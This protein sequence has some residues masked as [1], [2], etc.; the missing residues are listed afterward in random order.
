M[1]KVLLAVAIGAAAVVIAGCSSPAKQRAEVASRAQKDMVGMS[2]KELFGCAGT[3][4]RSERIDDTEFLTYFGGG[5]SV[6]A[7]VV[8]SNGYGTVAASKN[9]RRYCE[10]TFAIKDGLIQSVNY[11]GRTGGSSSKGEQCAF[12]VENCV[13]Q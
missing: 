6:G 1:K 4:V 9:S 7:A 13:H 11:Q 5:D 2:K 3:P 12:I 8:S 10:A